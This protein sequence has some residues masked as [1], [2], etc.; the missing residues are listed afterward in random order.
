MDGVRLE[1]ACADHGTRGQVV[2]RGAGAASDGQRVD[3]AGGSRGQTLSRCG[4]IWRSNCGWMRSAFE[5]KRLAEAGQ[6]SDNDNKRK[7]GS[8][9]EPASRHGTNETKHCYMQFCYSHG[10]GET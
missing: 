3:V 1:C 5:V 4:M 10:R 6:H 7:G 2:G 9:E 8:G